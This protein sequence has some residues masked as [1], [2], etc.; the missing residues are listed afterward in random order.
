MSHNEGNTGTTDFTFTITRSG[1]STGTSK[2]TY[3]TA[4][5]TATSPSDYTA[6]TATTLTF[7]AGQTSKTVT[8]KVNGDVADEDDEAFD[9]NLSNPVNAII[10]T[11]TGVGTITNDDG[12]PT[13]SI[14]D[15][16]KSEGNTGTTDFTFTVTRGGDTTQENVISYSTQDGTATV[17][18]SEYAAESNQLVV[19]GPGDV[20]RRSRLRSTAI[21]R[22]SRTRRSLSTSDVPT[23]RL[24]LSHSPWRWSS[25]SS[26]AQ[27]RGRFSTMIS[28][29]R[30]D[31]VD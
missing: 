25:R 10:D 24:S 26:S 20:T 7:T 14:N 12:P 9:V 6:I 17:T 29:R 22:S 5:D 30:P 2:I 23:R 16:S 19:F 27:A 21:P 4:D 28:R 8:V 18:D 11:G 15:V 3:A 1:G 31:G 13:F